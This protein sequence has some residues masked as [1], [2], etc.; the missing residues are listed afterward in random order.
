MMKV[1]IHRVAR[2]VAALA[3][4]PAAR[5]PGSPNNWEGSAC[6]LKPF[7]APPLPVVGRGGWGVR[8]GL[9]SVTLWC[10]IAA[11]PAARAQSFGPPVQTEVILQ[12]FDRQG[13]PRFTLAGY[14]AQWQNPF[15]VGVT[16]VSP[17]LNFQ[18]VSASFRLIG[19]TPASPLFE[20]TYTISPRWRAGFWYNPIRGERLRK[21]VQVADVPIALNLSRDT[22]LGDLHVVYY[23]PRGLSAQMGYFRERGKVQ[24]RSAEHL[25]STRYTRASWNFWVTQR[26]DARVRGRLV[27]PFLS[28]GYHPSSSLG[29]PVS[30]QPGVGVVL[31]ERLSLSGSV[32]LF[33]LNHTYTRI[34]AGLEYRL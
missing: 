30:L 4:P 33:D 23:G 2:R 19:D 10:S 6:Y 17:A 5:A 8:A 28:V 12:F 11:T 31:N 16:T 18:P 25:P 26:L 34:T 27:T 3:R 1:A 32:W 15:R 21:L 29:Y 7:H 13:H 9:L 20:G 24:D 22:D 14:I